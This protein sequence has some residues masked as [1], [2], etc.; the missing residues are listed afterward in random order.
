MLCSIVQTNGSGDLKKSFV[1]E[2]RQLLTHRLKERQ[3]ENRQIA[4]IDGYQRN[5]IEFNATMN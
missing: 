3:M 4:Q 2:T 1:Q 5:L